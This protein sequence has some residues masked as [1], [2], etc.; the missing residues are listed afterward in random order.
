[1]SLSLSAAFAGKGG[2]PA[3]RIEVVLFRLDAVLFD[4]NSAAL[5]PESLL[6]NRLLV[7]GAVGA[8]YNVSAC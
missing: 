2:L 1:M 5:V 3:D 6:V 8:A 7:A 4:S